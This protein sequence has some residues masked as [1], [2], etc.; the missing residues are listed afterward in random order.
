MDILSLSFK[1][2]HPQVEEIPIEVRCQI[3]RDVVNWVYPSNE[4]PSSSRRNSIHEN[5]NKR[6]ERIDDGRPPLEV[7]E[8]A[9][10]GE[11]NSMD[12]N[13]LLESLNLLRKLLLDDLFYDFLKNLF[14]SFR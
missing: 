13:I 10:E 7:E 11:E 4:T 2:K 14:R 3:L 6:N 8:L 1:S 5:E 12:D 9:R